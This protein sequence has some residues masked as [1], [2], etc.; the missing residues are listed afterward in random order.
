MS[1]HTEI[2]PHAPVACP[3]QCKA[4]NLTRQTLDAHR[5]ECPNEPVPCVHA[6]LG[7]SHVGPRYEIVQHEQNSEVHFSALRSKAI[8]EQQQV[9]QQ[10]LDKMRQMFEKKLEE[11][12]TLLNKKQHEQMVLLENKLEKH[13]AAFT[14]QQKEQAQLLEEKLGQLL[15]EKLEQQK[16]EQKEQAQ[17]LEEKLEEQKC[18]QMSL[19]K[20]ALEGITSSLQPL[21]DKVKAETEAEA[22]KRK[23][24]KVG[25]RTPGPYRHSNDSD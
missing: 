20:K 25:R 13:I 16:R 6:P 21:V 5:R 11:Q 12:M 18:K 19:L 4:L 22:A 9:Y 24:L 3:Q 7:C 2:C 15:E 1:T 17:L 8:A 10:Q 14:K 23:G